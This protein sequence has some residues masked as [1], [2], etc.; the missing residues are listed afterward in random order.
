MLTAQEV[1]PL[2]VHEDHPVR[3][4]AI[5]YFRG[6]W[7]QDVEVFALILQAYRQYGAE[8]SRLSLAWCNHFA[9]SEQSL[10]QVLET[11]ATATDPII[12]L[13]LN[14]VVA[15]APIALQL[16]QESAILD[17]PNL[18]PNTVE[19]INQRRD[20]A[21]WPADKLWNELQ[22]FAER[23]EDKQYANDIDHGYVDALI[24][25]LSQHDE[26][27]AGTICDLLESVGEENGWLEIFLVDLAGER[28]LRETIPTLV[29]KYRID[30]DYML[31]RVT[32]ALDKIG[33][34]EAVRL[35]RSV[36]PNES[37]SFKNF[38][39][40]VL[41]DIKHQESEDALLALLETEEDPSLRTM[42]CIELC[43]LFSAR[44]VDV[45]LHEIRSGYDS[46]IDCL[47]ETVLPVAH[48]LGIDIPEADEWRAERE[49]RERH[50]AERAVELDELGRRYAATK[51]S[52]IDP[53]AGLGA[54]KETAVE[55][56]TTIRFESPRVGRND[57]C[58][59]GSGKKFK[60]CCARKPR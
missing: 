8:E 59:C 41:G 16:T 6:T 1:K 15:D 17:T 40:A 2:L 49:V 35:I 19:A 18:L 46:E 34:P 25:A 56:P 38:A 30:T 50:R 21:Q 44:G 28:Q 42:L 37:W 57:P 12:A 55:E 7:S 45:I 24:A 53:L 36:F 26:P 10:D 32:D 13:H 47:E 20:F 5:N 23:S 11:L 48:V 33:D 51:A 39:T 43:Q 29:D 58:P 54:E 31:E 22:D 60:K 9:L 27:D 52:G 14:R 3:D 4:A